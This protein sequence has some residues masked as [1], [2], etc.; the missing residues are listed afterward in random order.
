VSDDWK[1][2]LIDGRYLVESTLGSGGM[3]L[4][5]KATHKFTGAKVALKV[6]RPELTLDTEVQNRFLGE[7]RAPSAIGHPGIVQVVDAGKAADGLLYL[8]MELLEGKTLRDAMARGNMPHPEIRRIMMEL[9]EALTAAHE[10]GFV[11]RDLKPENVFLSGTAGT[12]KLLDFGIAKVLDTAM[13]RVHTAHGVTMGTPA[14]MAPEQVSN[15]SGV[16]ARADLWAAGVMIYEMLCGKLPF[17]GSTTAEF[18]AAISTKE[19]TPIRAYLSSATPAHEKFFAKAL[20]REVFRRFQ[21]AQ[22]MAQGFTSLEQPLGLAQPA[23]EVSGLGATMATGPGLHPNPQTPMTGQTP[24]TPARV[25]SPAPVPHTPHP[26]YQTPVPVA[27]APHLGAAAPYPGAPAPQH[28]TPMPVAHAPHPGAP[29]PHPGAHQ[30][31]MPYAKP[32]AHGVPP[33]STAYPAGATMPVAPLGAAPA[34]KTNL[35]IGILGGVCMSLAV[36]IIVLTQCRGNGKTVAKAHA[37][38]AVVVVQAPPIDAAVV[39]PPPVDA[40]VVV[41][42]PPDARLRPAKRDAGTGTGPADPYAQIDAPLALAPPVDAGVS[43][44]IPKPSPCAARGTSSCR[45][46]M[47]CQ[48]S[49][50]D[51]AGEGDPC[52]CSCRAGVSPANVAALDAFAKCSRDCGYRNL[53]QARKCGGEALTCGAR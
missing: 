7:A 25:A 53:C 5:L 41:A 2:R 36:L 27:P 31:P 52:R 16:D 18:L 28:Q 46:A 21:S 49:C 4:V 50:E 20:A 22:E 3:G 34:S 29:A 17:I 11:H 45:A 51:D 30:T 37:D 9:F 32:G 14:Y 48:N 1:G 15:A 8:V 38:A 44:P 23:N 13:A 19:P 39:A 24:Q 42:A 6:L 40:T 47:K 43:K 12:V 26:G 10:R 35:I 33:V